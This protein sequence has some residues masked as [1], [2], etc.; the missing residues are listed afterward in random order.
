MATFLPLKSAGDL[1]LAAARTVI[2]SAG[3]MLSTMPMSWNGSSCEIPAATAAEPVAR[4]RSQ[5]PAVIAVLISAPLAI[6]VQL[7]LPPA[8]ESNHPS[9]LASMVGL[10]SVKNPTLT[11]AGIAAAH[12][13]RAASSPAAAPASARRLVIVPSVML[14]VLSCGRCHHRPAQ[15]TARR[16][17]SS[18]SRSIPMPAR[19]IMPMPTNT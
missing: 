11:V 8:P 13:P 12:A 4:P 2:S 16:S 1:M 17:T 19:P 18:S 10:V 3:P 14:V 6:S 7:I 5:L 9:P 15:C